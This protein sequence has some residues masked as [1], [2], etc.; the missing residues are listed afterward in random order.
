MEN[1]FKR[2]QAQLALQEK[3][4]VELKKHVTKCPEQILYFLMLERKIN[5]DFSKELDTFNPVKM[6]NKTQKKLDFYD[7][8]YNDLKNFKCE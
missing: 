7:K 3:I 2:R 5:R 8:F 6:Y 4:D 1:I